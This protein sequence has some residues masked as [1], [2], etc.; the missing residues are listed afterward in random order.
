[1]LP[2][3]AWRGES[4]A[5]I[6]ARASKTE[7]RRIPLVE[8]ETPEQLAARAQPWTFTT[9]L[10]EITPDGLVLGA[11]LGSIEI[12]FAQVYHVEPV[13]PWPSVALGWVDR[14][15]S[16]STVLTP[17]EYLAEDFALRVEEVVTTWEQRVGRA[18]RRGWLEVPVHAWE[19]V[20]AM[21][22]E[23]DEGP[24]FF[25]YRVAPGLADPIVARRTTEAGAPSL[26]TWLWARL[27]P[28][29]RR[30]DAREVVLTQRY[31]YVRTRAG[32]ALR[33][34]V[35]TL[36][37]ARR[38]SFGDSIYVFGRSTELLLVQQQGC[39]VS[40]ALDARLTSSPSE[41]E[42]P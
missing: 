30:V 17:R 21:P 14:G 32:E 6:V 11:G 31:V 25:G 39:P 37:T 34:P 36:R 9:A 23:R 33:V 26:W 24:R 19:R 7:R 10:I 41:H 27:R 15:E 4:W 3:V 1:M 5:E 12:G 40:A 42:L 13:D 28:L 29:P 35:G 16:Y 22:G 18:A 20:D 8:R 38:T 2:A